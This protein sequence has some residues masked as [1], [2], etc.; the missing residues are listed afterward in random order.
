MEKEHTFFPM[1]QDQVKSILKFIDATETEATKCTIFSQLGRECFQCSPMPEH[2]AQ[3]TDDP[4][5]YLDHINVEQKSPF[6][7]SLIFSDDKTTLILTGRKVKGCACAFADCDDPP[8]SLCNYCCK[9]F[10]EAYFK[11]LF[12]RDVEVEITEA[13]LLGGERCSTRVHFV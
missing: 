5:V 6:W 13:F 2:V 7:E 10:Q 12:G 9:S 4:Q 8:L 3:F 11:A 1:N